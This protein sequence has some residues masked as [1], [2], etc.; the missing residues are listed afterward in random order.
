MNAAPDE[1]RRKRA[2]TANLTSTRDK[3]RPR[4]RGSRVHYRHLP[5]VTDQKRPGK[6]ATNT[7]TP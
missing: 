1:I 7:D 2:K 6:M 3:Q 5:S 4:Q